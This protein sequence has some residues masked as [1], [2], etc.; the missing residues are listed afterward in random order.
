M[1][2]AYYDIECYPNFFS[3]LFVST[4]NPQSI[5]DNYVD[6]DIN[7]NEELKKEILL[8]LDHRL[9]IV[10]SDKFSN[11]V[12]INHMT[13][14]YKFIDEIKIL[15]GFNSLGYDNLLISHLLIYKDRYI[16]PECDWE[17]NTNLYNLNE[18]IINN[19]WGNYKY[20]DKELS[21]FYEPFRSLD[22]FKCLLETTERKSLK[23]LGIILQW[24][25][26]EDLPIKHGSSISKNQ[27]FKIIDYNLNDVLLTRH[28]HLSSLDEVALKVDIST[29]YELDLLNANRSK[30]AEKLLTKFYAEN[31]GIKPYN[32]KKLRTNR[33][34]IKFGDI[35]NPRIK[36]AT[37]IL[38]N[39]HN[40]LLNTVYYVND[41]DTIEKSSFSE[42]VLFK[43]KGYRLGVGGLHSID[44]PK[45]YKVDGINTIMRDADVSSYY[46]KLV[47]N[48]GVCPAHIAPLAFNA[49]VKMVTNKRLESKDLAKKYKHVDNT[50]FRKYDTLAKALKIVANSGLFGFF[51][52]SDKWLFDIKCTYQTTLNGQLYLLMLIEQLEEIG[53]EVISANTDGIVS[54][55]KI[56]KETSYNTICADWQNL[57]NLSLEFTDYSKYIRTSVNDY[58][59][60]KPQFNLTLNKEYVKF[61]GDFI[62]KPNIKKGYNA[63]VIA[64]A[65]EMFYCN[66]MPIEK[67]IKE[68]TNIYDFCISVKT[69]DAFQK[70]IHSMKNGDFNILQ[71]SKNLRYYVSNNGGTLIKQSETQINQM[72]KG[73]LVTPFNDFF[74]VT[75][76]LEY[77][78]NYN[79]YI[80]RAY[81]IIYKIDG[82]YDKPKTSRRI[83]SRTGRGTKII[84]GMFDE[85]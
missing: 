23:Q 44:R 84:G 58:I 68:H 74:K 47:E 80:K 20:Q 18:S 82:V 6:A 61:K 51:G 43:D 62:S 30:I 26:I 45:I 10:Y 73:F 28:L 67:T 54:R 32:F 27:I 41:T 22:L 29:E 2:G 40:K 39:L 38:Q 17:I 52:S 42:T 57:T 60:I 79:Y 65:L 9:F 5:I 46:P 7:K 25:R 3:A 59:A 64:H 48:E 33:V 1:T 77:N 70:E 13:E 19:S 76:F 31:T 85:I 4:T 12:E 83:T 21:A 24:Y 56:D 71:L 8:T 37:S 81:D 72:L 16:R 63:P 78:I 11:K 36:F 53:I 55:F 49:I 34:S 50:L 75:N 35:L 14:F 15:I 66:D 69:G